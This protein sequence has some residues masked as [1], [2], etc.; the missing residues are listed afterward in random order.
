MPV[1]THTDIY[2]Y[3]TKILQADLNAIGLWYRVLTMFDSV[4]RAV[5]KELSLS[6][7]YP[8]GHGDMFKIWMIKHHTRA[9][10]LLVESST[11]SRHDLVVEGAATVYWN[12]RSAVCV[13]YV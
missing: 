6:E 4:L 7:K 13:I 2:K 11:G 9:L 5:D 12:R 1:N 10:L 3:S 8:K